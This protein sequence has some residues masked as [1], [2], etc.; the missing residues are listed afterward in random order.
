[1]LWEGWTGDHKGARL[2]L[3]PLPPASGLIADCGDHSAWFRYELGARG[4]APYIRSSKSRKKLYPRDK[5]LCRQRHKVENLF[6]GL[7][8][9]RCVA[10]RYDRCARIFFS[11]ISIAATATF[12]L[13]SMSPGPR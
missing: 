10:T 6:A 8:D 9:W 2:V 7:K 4:I 5:A 1:M 13:R 3:D 11:A 12:W